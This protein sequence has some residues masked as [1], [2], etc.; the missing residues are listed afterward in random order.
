VHFIIELLGAGAASVGVMV[1]GYGTGRLLARGRELSDWA[2][3]KAAL[4][5][6]LGLGLNGLVLFL[7]G[8]WNWSLATVV[9]VLAVPFVLGVWGLLKTR[10]SFGGVN[11][12]V[13]AVLAICFL[14]GFAKPVGDIGNDTVSYHLLGPE[15]WSVKG[16]IRPALDHSHT[17]MPATVETLFGA[18]MELSNDRSPGVI[19]CFF[20]ALLLIQVAGFARKLGGPGQGVGVAAMLAAT[21][22]AIVD[23]SNNGFVDL[24]YACFVMAS[25]RAVVWRG[26]DVVGGAFAGFSMGTKYTGLIFTGIATLVRAVREKRSGAVVFAVVA[27]FVGC[28]WYVRNW[29]LLGSPVYPIPAVLGSVFHSDTFPTAAVTGFQ[30]YILGRGKGVGRGLIY[31]LELPVTFTYFT[32][33]FHG[34]GGIGLAPLGLAP[35]GVYVA[36]KQREVRLLLGLCFLF[37]LTW[38]VTQQ[39]S[40]FL[41]PIICVGA[42]LAGVGAELALRQA[43]R[44]RALTWAI[45]GISV[46]YGG[47]VIAQ[48]EWP[49]LTWLRG[50]QAE[51]R[52]QMA[53]VPYYS[54]FGYLNETA[55]VKRVLILNKL[56]PTY[57]LHK[58]YVKPLGPYGERTVAG[59][60]SEADAL[61]QAGSMGITH[62]LEVE[63]KAT[64]L[65]EA[66]CGKLTVMFSSS[67]AR[68][69]R[70][71]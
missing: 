16:R 50:P 41:V 31:F 61:G 63:S 66:G 64:P 62:V 23:F 22:P 28:A 67:E 47:I 52:R 7:V 59:V 26:G 43:G 27:G 69:Y 45:V 51:L 15:T 34:A 60:E 19:D 17:A 24:A 37:T 57:Y 49:R 4:E 54:A 36:R 38:F 46:A 6:L 68:V 25:M 70:C 10:F 12:V 29:V 55:E 3:E 32:A 44:T 40:R 42:A 58:L 48:D 2:P 53:Q 11:C 35:L 33:A 18:G 14:G 5:T 21:M 20:F 1:A 39:E 9:A 30:E 56:V 65:T 8:C 13:C 71:N